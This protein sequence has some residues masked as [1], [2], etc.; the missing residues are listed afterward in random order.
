MIVVSGCYS[1]CVVKD[2][3]HVTLFDSH[4]RNGLGALI[5][6]SSFD[7]L[8]PITDNIL[9]EDPKVPLYYSFV[10]VFW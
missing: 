3:N 6:C 4:S 10:D 7:N 9:V 5:V 2:D 8:S 1:A